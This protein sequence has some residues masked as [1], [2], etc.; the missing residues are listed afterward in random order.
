M[1][2]VFQSFHKFTKHFNTHV[3]LDISEWPPFWRTKLY[4]SYPRSEEIVLSSPVEKALKINLF[5][6][7]FSTKIFKKEQVI[8]EEAISY[9]L[10][11]S[12]ADINT[13]QVTKR[14]YPS[15]GARHPLEVYIIF[16]RPQAW[17]ETGVYH[18]NPDKHSLSLI[19]KETGNHIAHPVAQQETY[20]GVVI[21]LTAVFERTISKYGDRGYRFILQESGHLAQNIYLTASVHDLGVCA[22]GFDVDETME[23]DWLDIDGVNESVVYTLFVGDSDW[24][25]HLTDE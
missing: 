19:K 8:T 6:D 4:K 18:Y 25:Q 12:C 2:S 3:P 16:T 20:P 7:R 9:I 10:F 21:V 1:F 24:A 13:G 5:R 14:P 15:A 23:N 17:A 11:N 22:K